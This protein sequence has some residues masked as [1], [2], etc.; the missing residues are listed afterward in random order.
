MYRDDDLFLS[1]QFNFYC[2]FRRIISKE[3]LVDL[4]N[5]AKKYISSIHYLNYEKR[6][7]LI[8]FIS[9]I[10]EAIEKNDKEKFYKARRKE[11]LNILKEVIHMTNM[12]REDKQFWD[13][14]IEIAK[15]MT[16]FEKRN[17][18]IR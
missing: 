11:I 6:K 1:F 16:D 4:L 9:E 18:L 5:S 2:F 8:E 12:K 7:E 17:R 14:I 15:K 3:Q 13:K 10:E